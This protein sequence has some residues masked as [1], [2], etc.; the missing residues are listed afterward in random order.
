MKKALYGNGGQALEIATLFDMQFIFVVD[1]E[2]ADEKALPISGISPEEYEILVCI[3]DSITRKKIVDKLKRFEFFSL[4]HPS[5]IIAKNSSIGIGTYIGPYNIIT[6]DVIIGN[7]SLISRLNSVGHNVE[8]GDYLSMMPGAILSG[9]CKLGECV[10]MGNNSSVREKVSIC[11]HV[12][13]GMN[14]AVVKDISDA[15]TYVGIPAKR[16]TC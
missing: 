2:Y 1:D 8:T 7:H 16:I 9:N 6:N 3:G 5:A 13:I 12:K 15:G 11:N 4:I 14:A 10:Y